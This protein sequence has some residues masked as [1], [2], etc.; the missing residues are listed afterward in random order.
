MIIKKGSKKVKKSKREGKKIS[1]ILGLLSGPFTECNRHYI[2][3]EWPFARGFLY[4][5]LPDLQRFMSWLV[6]FGADV[7]RIFNWVC[8]AHDKG[9]I[10]G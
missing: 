10:N 3:H 9:L 6:D 7:S 1:A 4:P 8:N 2:Y 5:V